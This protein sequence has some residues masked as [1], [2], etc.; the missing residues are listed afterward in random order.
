VEIQ[1]EARWREYARMQLSYTY[2]DSWDQSIGQPLDYVPPHMFSVSLTWAVPM[3]DF[4][5]SGSFSEVGVS[6]RPYMLWQAYSLNQLRDGPD[7]LDLPVQVTLPPYWR[8]D[9]TL[10]L[11][12]KKRA[13][14]AI[15]GTNLTD[16]DYEESGHVRA[17]GRMLAVRLGGAF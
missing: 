17:P 8:S 12:Y 14:V 11:S 1:A 7:D 6:E 15:S 16:R 13:F 2:T 4:V 3:G 10:R 9:A 5:I